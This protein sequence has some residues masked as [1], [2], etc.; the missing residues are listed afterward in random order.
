MALV[1]SITIPLGLKMPAFELKDPSGKIYQS[2]TVYGSKGLLVAFTCNHCPYAQAVWP[3]LIQ[4]AQEAQKLGV[5]TV[6]I[7]PNIH[8]GY[9]DDAPDRM[10]EK[11]KEWRISFPYLVDETQEVAREFRAQCTPDLYLFDSSHQLVYHGR[12]DDNWKEPS[13]VKK[14]ELKEAIQNLASGKP[15]SERQ[16]PSMGCSIKWRD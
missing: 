14:R 4:L 1:E 7:N 2:D 5:N 11:I 13:Q 12:V 10:K 3:R 16:L 15:I 8:P 6:G 9:P